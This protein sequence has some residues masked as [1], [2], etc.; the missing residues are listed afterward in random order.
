[1]PKP[2]GHAFLHRVGWLSFAF[3]L[4]K[5]VFLKVILEFQP[6]LAVSM[7]EDL[8]WTTYQHTRGV[9]SVFQDF[10]TYF[11]LILLLS[12][13]LP[14]IGQGLLLILLQALFG[15]LYYLLDVYVIEVWPTEVT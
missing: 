3:Y 8:F 15:G 13:A 6:F 14:P 11:R 4:K 9:R 1:M 10:L 12:L 5:G 7:L 2:L